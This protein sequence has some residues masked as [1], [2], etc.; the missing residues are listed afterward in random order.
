MG[1]WTGRSLLAVMKPSTLH[2]H[3]CNPAENT[4]LGTATQ[5]ES[6]PG[7]TVDTDNSLD[8]SPAQANCQACDRRTCCTQ[9]TARSF[10]P[11]ATGAAHPASQLGQ[12]GLQL[13]GRLLP[14]GVLPAAI[15][16]GHRGQSSGVRTPIRHGHAWACETRRDVPGAQARA[17]AGIAAGIAGVRVPRSG[18]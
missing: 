6:A 9:R 7:P 5:T 4:L 1:L 3:A 14:P 17:T 18:W 2:N 16:G 8:S 10:H 15:T 13:R 11:S 12:P